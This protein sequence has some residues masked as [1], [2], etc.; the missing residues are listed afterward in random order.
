MKGAGTPS[1]VAVLEPFGANVAREDAL[2][3]PPVAEESAFPGVD[4]GSLGVV[5]DV[6]DDVGW[7]LGVLVGGKGVEV[8]EGGRGGGG[9][10]A[11]LRTN[12]SRVI[13]ELP[14]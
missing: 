9:S 13:C 6:L 2:E 5:E 4:V 3:L 10:A 1:P 7:F 11:M 8:D 12:R 14:V